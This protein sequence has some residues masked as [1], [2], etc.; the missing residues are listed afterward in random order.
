MGKKQK[1]EEKAAHGSLSLF[2]AKLYKFLMYR[3]RIFLLKRGKI[4]SK[5]IKKKREYE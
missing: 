4:R 2:I 3:D 5:T 1:T